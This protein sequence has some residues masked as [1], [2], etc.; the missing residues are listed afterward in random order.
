MLPTA[1]LAA[2]TATGDIPGHWAADTIAQW[3]QKGYISGY[4]DGSF[5]PDSSITRAEFIKIANRVLNL[6]DEADISFTD[7]QEGD[8][9]CSEVKK[10]VAAGYKDPV[11][12]AWVELNQQIDAYNNCLIGAPVSRDDQYPVNIPELTAGMENVNTRISVPLKGNQ[13]VI[14]NISSVAEIKIVCIDS[15]P[16][17]RN[18][19]VTR[20]YTAQNVPGFDIA[21]D[22]AQ[23]SIPKEAITLTDW[24]I[25]DGWYVTEDGLVLTTDVWVCS[26]TV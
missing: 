18:L 17:L 9:F 10:A 2:D 4:S 6:T 14:D 12:G 21:A 26:P 23:L 5:R 7:V 20:V 3:Q 13:R 22:T 19:R 16:L 11:T 1:A 8:W 24:A 15:T 25:E